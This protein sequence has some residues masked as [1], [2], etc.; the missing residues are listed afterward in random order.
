M[1]KGADLLLQIIYKLY[2]KKVKVISEHC[3]GY[4]L[5]LDYYLPSY[6][7]GFEYHGRQH[8]NYVDH[9]HKSAGGF[10]ASKRRDRI[11]IEKAME[12]GITLVTVWHHETITLE[13]VKNKILESLSKE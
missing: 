8:D 2:G 5:R 10:R 3:I 4:R 1:S 11:K 9:Y 12:E 13:L 7:I 6:K